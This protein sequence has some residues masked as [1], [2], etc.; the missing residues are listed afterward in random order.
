[1]IPL[2]LYYGFFDPLYTGN[3]GF[4]WTPESSIRQLQSSNVQYAN[5]L[6]LVSDVDQRV[7]KINQDYKLVSSTT[8]SKVELMLPDSI[9]PIK[10]RNEVIAIADKAG[11]SINGLTVNTD[12]IKS[13]SNV[14]AYII[15]FTVKA[16]YASIKKLLE[17]YEKNKRFFTIDSLAIRQQ[18]TKNL[19]PEEVS[20]LD[21]E[22]IQA[23]VRFNVYY[24]KK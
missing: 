10:L 3:P 1:M 6:V 2:V 5:S 17:E 20:R 23:T 13:N 16:R 8:T 22:A 24:L 4:V 21:K 11:I 14:G 9:D 7:K 18:D 19:S 12:D 15:S